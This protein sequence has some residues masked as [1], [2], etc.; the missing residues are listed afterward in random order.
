MT[1]GREPISETKDWCT[2]PEYV[3]AVRRVFIAGIGLDP[4][5]NAHSTVGADRQITPPANG[6]AVPWDASTVYVNPPYG[7]DKARGT[8]IRD[9]LAKCSEAALAGS[10]VLALVP[11]ATN[12]R[13]W[14]DHV[15]AATSICF[16]KVPR[17]KFALAGEAVPKG[18]PMACA[19]VYWGDRGPGILRFRTVFGAFGA[20]LRC[21]S[22]PQA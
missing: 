19:M 4:C 13:H 18:A 5:S 14:R 1:A 9:W 6:L 8:T 12:T 3:D 22:E 21:P 2:P 10:Q 7:R 20:V 17:L 15:F 11:V 16:L